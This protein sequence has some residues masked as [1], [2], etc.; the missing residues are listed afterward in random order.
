MRILPVLLIQAED[1]RQSRHHNAENKRR[2]FPYF[3]PS[4]NII[5]STMPLNLQSDT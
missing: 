3:S 2:F 5:L 1:Y 4:I